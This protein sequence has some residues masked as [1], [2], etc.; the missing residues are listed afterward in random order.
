M[1]NQLY[2]EAHRG[3]AVEQTPPETPS[4]TTEKHDAGELGRALGPRVMGAAAAV[5]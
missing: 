5:L 4:E 3:W 2:L 1:V